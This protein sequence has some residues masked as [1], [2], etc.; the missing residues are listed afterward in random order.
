MQTSPPNGDNYLWRCRS[1]KGSSQNGWA[2]SLPR[3]GR[4][5][6]IRRGPELIHIL[7]PPLLLPPLPGKPAA[8]KKKLPRVTAHGLSSRFS[9]I[10]HG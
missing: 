10:V 9:S 5:F 3:K 8:L 4:R 1:L 6:Q 2:L 7:L